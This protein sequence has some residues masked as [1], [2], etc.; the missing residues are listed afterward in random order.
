MLGFLNERDLCSDTQT[1]NKTMPVRLHS[2]FLMQLLPQ[3]SSR[4][5][6]GYWAVWAM[7]LGVVILVSVLDALVCMSAASCCVG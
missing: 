5:S 3:C 7:L 1:Q 6:I 2:T 4:G